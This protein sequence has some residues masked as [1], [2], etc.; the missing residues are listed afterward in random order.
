[1][2]SLKKINKHYYARFVRRE[3]GQRVEKTFSLKTKSKKTADSLL[4]R[5]ETDSELGKIDVFNEFNFRKWRD[6]DF[7]DEQETSVHLQ[8][9]IAE[10]I[11]ESTHR[12]PKTLAHYKIVLKKFCEQTGIS[13]P[14]KEVNA[15]DIRDYCFKP[16][17]SPNTSNNYLRHIKTFFN[18]CLDKGLIDSNPAVGIKKKPVAEKLADQILSKDDF[19]KLL[20]TMREKIQSKIA[21]RSVVTSKQSQKWLEPIFL[22][23]YHGGLRLSEIINLRWKNI[24]F[25]ENT[26]IV[27]DGKGGKSRTVIIFDDLKKA[28][29]D[30]KEEAPFSGNGDYVFSSP[31]CTSESKPLYSDN[32][33]AAFRQYRKEAKLADSIHF[34]SLRH[35]CATNMLNSGFDIT[36]VKEMLG[37]ASIEVT[38]RYLH[39][40]A[41]DIQERAKK[42][43]LIES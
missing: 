42:L 26:I 28:L 30:W 18:W 11:N 37:H 6:S 34:H 41:N 3:N 31:T 12:G 5:L 20:H 38:Q 32:I 29:F 2:A 24:D 25:K 7:I 39:L 13:M 15:S 14:L 23:S 36:H 27:I 8:S 33:S 40:T 4:R 35:S 16:N 19:K 9:A 43:G 1:M 21:S 22:V 17:I 10:F